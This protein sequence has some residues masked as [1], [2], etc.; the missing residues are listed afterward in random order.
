MPID[1]LVKAVNLI[2]SEQRPVASKATK[3]PGTGS[4]APGS[5]AVG[6]YAIL[7]ALLF[8]V[9]AMAL[10]VLTNNDIKKNK[11]ELAQVEQEAEIV[12]KQASSLQAFADFKQLSAARMETVR[13]LADARFPWP[14]TLDDISRAL[15]DDVFISS[16]DGA[17][18]GSSSGS[19]LR[20]A[21]V[22]PS[23]ELNGCTSDQAGVARLMARLRDVR[24]VTR[25]TLA[26]SER[27]ET[28]DT[29]AAPAPATAADGTTPATTSEPCPDGAPPAFDMIVFFERAAVSPA[30][31]P[32]SSATA[33]G[34][35]GAAGAQGPTGAAGATAGGTTP[36]STTTTP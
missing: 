18:S 27:S 19:S 8:A 30:A 22:A 12:E 10:M 20:G 5:G 11:A 16:F 21:I 24:G 23:I 3:G 13:G 1:G 14:E 33:Q 4:P 2:P 35:T 26:K 6:A 15:P 7:G 31:A 28:A 9:A 34:P 17:T 29:A 32:N 25:V 36:T